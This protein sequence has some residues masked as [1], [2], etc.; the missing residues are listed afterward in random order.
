MSYL[1]A[2]KKYVNVDIYGKCGTPC[3]N[4]G[5]CREHVTNKHKFFFAFEN[6]ICRDYITEKFFKILRY[7]VVPVVMG[8]GDYSR[9]V[10]LLIFMFYILISKLNRFFVLRFLSLLILT[11]WITNHHKSWENI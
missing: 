7:N 10:S 1:M 9:F 4:T 5:D 6:C 3:P 2:L 11:L 8:G